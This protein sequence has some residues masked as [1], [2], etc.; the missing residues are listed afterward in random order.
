MGCGEIGD[1]GMYGRIPLWDPQYVT[2][3][4]VSQNNEFRTT[5]TI[6]NSTHN[7][8]SYHSK[9]LT[10]QPTPTRLLDLPPEAIPCIADFLPVHSAASLAFCNRGLSLLLGPQCW[11]PV[12]QHN[13]EARIPF[14]SALAK[15]LP[16]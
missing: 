1:A 16:R 8:G 14:L 15:D 3:Y 9:G 12:R 5:V 2:T 11:E 4:H 13:H 10:N 6:W 7:M